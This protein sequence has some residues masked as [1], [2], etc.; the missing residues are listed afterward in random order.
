MHNI[1]VTWYTGKVL[2]RIN[3][4]MS[5]HKDMSQASLNSVQL[6]G[7]NMTHAALGNSWETD[8]LLSALEVER[9]AHAVRQS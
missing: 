9:H 4:N 3:T 1:D 2:V 7:S 6:W 5:T 8:Y